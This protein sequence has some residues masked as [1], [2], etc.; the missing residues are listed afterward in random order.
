[1][2][3]AGSFPFRFLVLVG[4]EVITALPVAPGQTLASS[5]AFS[6]TVSDSSGNRIANAGVSLTNAENGVTLDRRR[7][8]EMSGG[9]SEF[10]RRKFVTGIASVLAASRVAAAPQQC[11]QHAGDF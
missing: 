5:A 2:S 11:R 7:L 8:S 3:L 6:R 1:M 4:L 9:S 10:N